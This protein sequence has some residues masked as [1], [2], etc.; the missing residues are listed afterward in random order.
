MFRTCVIL[1]AATLSLGIAAGERAGRVV[2]RLARPHPPNGL[3][4]AAISADGRYVAFVSA[5][6][7]LSADTNTLD[8]IY[9]LDR[10][11]HQLIIGA[12]R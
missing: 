9:V 5:A 11:T 10:D 2:L 12:K 4:T 8:D 7:L 6:R 1:I 3:P